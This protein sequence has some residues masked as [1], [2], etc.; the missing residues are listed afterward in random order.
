[1][2]D[3]RRRAKQKHRATGDIS[4]ALARTINDL[5]ETLQRKYGLD[6]RA[7]NSAILSAL[8]NNTAAMVSAVCVAPEGSSSVLGKKL[9]AEVNAFIAEHRGNQL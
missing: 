4:T 7:I 6:H 2:N 3:D 1:M 9:T 5:H 8:V